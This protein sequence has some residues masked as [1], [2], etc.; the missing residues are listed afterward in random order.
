MLL[1]GDFDNTATPREG[2]P[3][4]SAEDSDEVTAS[5]M[6]RGCDDGETRGD[7]PSEMLSPVAG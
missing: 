2:P 4:D 7:I 1:L 5:S 3:G 6:T